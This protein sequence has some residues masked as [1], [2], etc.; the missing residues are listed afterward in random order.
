[1][2]GDVESNVPNNYNPWGGG[3]NP[4]GGGGAGDGGG[5]GGFG[6]DENM[7]DMGSVAPM[8][9]STRGRE[10]QVRIVKKDDF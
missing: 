10:A 6:G 2:R 9:P 7:P 5:D 1:M 3:D 8:R 4:W